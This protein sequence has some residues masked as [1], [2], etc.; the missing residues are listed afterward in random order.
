MEIFGA[1]GIGRHLFSG[2]EAWRSSDQ[3]WDAV[4]DGRASQLDS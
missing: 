4:D 1:E 2:G 3:I